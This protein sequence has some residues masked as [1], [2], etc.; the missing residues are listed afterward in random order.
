MSSYLGHCNALNHMN[1]AT[2]TSNDGRNDILMMRI[3][4]VY[5]GESCADLQV[6]QC[7][8]LR[9][10]RQVIGHRLDFRPGGGHQGN[11]HLSLRRWPNRQTISGRYDVFTARSFSGLVHCGK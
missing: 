10:K 9:H 11:R 2:M 4:P 8:Q 7:R 1:I 3:P 5:P 6:L